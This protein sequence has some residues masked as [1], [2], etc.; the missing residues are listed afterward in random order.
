MN[1]RHCRHLA[2]TVEITG[3]FNY[4]LGPRAKTVLFWTF[5][6]VDHLL[7]WSRFRLVISPSLS[8]AA[9][10]EAN[11]LRWR[12]NVT[13]LECLHSE[14]ICM[15]VAIRRD[16][17]LAAH[18]V[19]EMGDADQR[20]D[21][22]VIQMDLGVAFLVG[23]PGRPGGK[24]YWPIAHK[25]SGTKVHQGN[26]PGVG[27]CGPGRNAGTG[28]IAIASLSWRFLC[29]FRNHGPWDTGPDLRPAD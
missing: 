26:A 16:S 28:K 21:D 27:R 19:P 15:G 2:R 7:P 8:G 13:I 22:A 11:N 4:P 20:R 5:A 14:S 6:S 12:A 25:P 18:A 17:S 24:T 23:L 1:F 3:F 10:A 29:N 9:I